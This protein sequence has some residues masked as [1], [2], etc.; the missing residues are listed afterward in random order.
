MGSSSVWAG[1]SPE[2]A[3]GECGSPATS[4]RVP[5]LTRM[6]SRI[7]ELV[8]DAADPERLAEFWSE[9]LGYV[10]LDREEDGSIQIGPPQTGFGGPQPL[11]PV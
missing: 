8:I 11:Q 6:A 7:S 9:I 1:S 3:P 4:G 2:N 10:E 5:T